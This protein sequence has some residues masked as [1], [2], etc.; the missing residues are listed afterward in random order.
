MKK[1]RVSHPALLLVLATAVGAFVCQGRLVDRVAYAYERGRLQAGAEYLQGLDS[2]EVAALEQVS[3]AF[4]IIADVVRPSVV[5]IKTR[6][7]L[8]LTE[9]ERLELFDS[10]T[11][12]VPPIRGT[13]S[14]IILDADGHI[15]TNF[16]VI[17]EAGVIDVALSDGREYR[18]RVV[19]SDPKTDIAV[20]RIDAERLHPAKLGDSDQVK[21]GHLVL[22]IGCPFR[23]G[24][25]VSHG[26]ISALG[27]AN[28]A[29]DI[30]Y[31]N[32]I[33][34]D[35]AINPGNSGGPLISTRGEVIGMSTAIA[36]EN[37]GHQGVGFAIPSNTISRIADRLRTGKPIERGY[38]GVVIQ[39]VTPKMAEAYKLPERGGVFV[40]NVGSDTPAARAGLRPEDIILAMNGRSVRTR[41]ELQEVIAWTTPGE[42]IELTVWRAGEEIRVSVTIEVQ[43]EGFS[44]IATIRDLSRWNRPEKT[45]SPPT[46]S[47]DSESTSPP[48]SQPL[49]EATVDFPDLGLTVSAVNEEMRKKFQIKTGVASGVLITGVAPVSEA[50]AATLAPG[51]VITQVNGE[52][53]R[54]PKD[55]EQA[56][57]KEALA[58]GVRLQVLA[59]NG[60]TFYTVLRLP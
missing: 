3:T 59:R 16:H 5:N 60:E 19:G 45:P 15:A 47:P 48:T 22:A 25:S 4:S 55:I 37:G 6:S 23:L 20:L 51:Q 33:Q 21:V 38:L 40:S 26:I 39:E 1:A 30:D 34:T 29:V 7:E 57:T 52:A 53:I 10:A 18:A 44:T 49:S 35:A 9:R 42:K 28:V 32:W 27:R 13:G 31:Q 50:Y 11:A 2:P 41:E 14:G 36:T 54:S 24:H 17:H 43:P 12:I 56:L 58:L 46:S 8:R